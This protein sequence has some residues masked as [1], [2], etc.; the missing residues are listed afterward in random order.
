MRNTVLAIAAAGILA[1]SPA[2]A[3]L[4]GMGLKV[5]GTGK[6]DNGSATVSGDEVDQFLA[7]TVNAT[8]HLAIAMIILNEAA[9]GHDK[10]G[11]QKEAITS[12]SQAKS[13][14]EINSSNEQLSSTAEALS[15]NKNLVDQVRVSY[16]AASAKEKAM[17]AAAIYNFALFLPELPQMPK[18]ISTLVSGIGSNPRMLGKVGEL[19]TAGSLIGLQLKGTGSVLKV[20][21]QLM[22]VAKV[23]APANAQ[24]SKAQEVTW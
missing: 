5:P 18:N 16:Q 2:H 12:L 24:P 17:I 4:G 14:K 1:A 9:A 19:K 7:K 20:L 6:S 10:L 21:P 11:A 8:K 22:T 23:K 3:Q 13:V 15:S